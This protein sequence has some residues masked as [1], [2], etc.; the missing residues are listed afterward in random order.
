MNF[1][2]MLHSGYPK[3][4]V[5]GYTCIKTDQ[6]QKRMNIS[7]C[8]TN[9]AFADLQAAIGQILINNVTETVLKDILQYHVIA[10]GAVKSSQLPVGA[11]ET[12]KGEDITISLTGSGVKL[13]ELRM[14]V[15]VAN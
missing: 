5:A 1:R 9:D 14:E 7:R 11:V 8:S 12:A 10:S 6:I 13:N 2:C 15:N 4:G 3:A